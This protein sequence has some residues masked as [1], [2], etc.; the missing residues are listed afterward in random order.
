[1]EDSLISV[2]KLPFLIFCSKHPFL[3]FRI[4]ITLFCSKR[5]LLFL[6]TNIVLDFS[7]ERRSDWKWQLRKSYCFRSRKTW[8]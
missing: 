4:Y 3:S 2:L 5:E 6:R 1:M 7:E 8:L